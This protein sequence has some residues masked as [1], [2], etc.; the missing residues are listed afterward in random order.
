MWVKGEIFRNFDDLAVGARGELDRGAQRS[1]FDR[2]EW[3]QRTW[4]LTSQVGLPLV[5]RARADGHNSWLFLAED[6]GH[7]RALVSWYSLS[8]GAVFSGQ[9]DIATKFA[10]IVATARRLAKRVTSITLMPMAGDDAST[11]IHAFDRARWITFKHETSVRW[12]I[13]TVGMSFAEYWAARPGELRATVK[14]KAAKFGIKP[15]IYTSFDGNAWSAY[16]AIYAASWKSEEGSPEFL[17]DMALFESAAGCLRLGIASVDDE[18]VAAQLWTV[19]NGHAII[20]K[21]AHLE[22]ARDTSSGSVLSAAMFQHV[23]DEDKVSLIDFG[24]GDDRYKADW[25]DT[26]TPLYTVC[27]FNPRRPAGLWGAAKVSLRA[28]VRRPGNR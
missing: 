22:S 11:V 23:I 3:Y 28:L 9:P 26:R 13:S 2:I 1:L 20:H 14:R 21:L 19:E 24:T 15:R 18:P 5:V 4:R 7:A 27:L 10:L 6:D 12:T 25:M 17:R 8:F 16:E